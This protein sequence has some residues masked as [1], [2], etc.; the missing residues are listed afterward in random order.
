MTDTL[1]L[2]ASKVSTARCQPWAAATLGLFMALPDAAVA[3]IDAVGGERLQV[4]LRR[5]ETKEASR[6]KA[7]SLGR[8]CSM[9]AKP[10]TSGVSQ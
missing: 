1:A 9:S 7:P 6:S 2:A 5:P 8:N 10:P 4:T 3:Q